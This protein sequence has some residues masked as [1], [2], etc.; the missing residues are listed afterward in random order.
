MDWAHWKIN[1]RIVREFINRS[2]DTIRWLEGLGCVF[3]LMAFFPNQTPVVSHRQIRRAM[4][5]DVLRKRCDEL[6][7]RILVR[8]G[9]QKIVVDPKKG[10]TGVVAVGR[11]G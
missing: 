10:V 11:N 3:E 5:A 9:A 6:G 7:V 4:V 1:P 2:G 8:T